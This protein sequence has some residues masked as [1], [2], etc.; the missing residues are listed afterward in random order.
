MT[1]WLALVRGL[2]GF[3]SKL[4]GYLK[5]NQTISTAKAAALKE[6]TDEALELAQYASKVD[7]S[8]DRLSG[9]ARER[10]RNVLRR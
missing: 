4:T 6:A 1:G 5:Q 2:L 9:P 8:T 3:A 7:Q 10:V